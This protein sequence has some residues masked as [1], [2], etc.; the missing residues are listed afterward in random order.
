VETKDDV[1]KL[2]MLKDLGV[3]GIIEM[4]KI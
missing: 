3:K 2:K 1:K 4:K